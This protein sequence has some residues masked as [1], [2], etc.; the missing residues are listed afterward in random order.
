MLYLPCVLSVLPLICSLLLCTGLPVLIT[1][2]VYGW[3]KWGFVI[4]GQLVMGHV[5]LSYFFAAV[6]L[7]ISVEVDS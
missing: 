4:V 2:V 5:R 1:C 6:A 7:L 3:G